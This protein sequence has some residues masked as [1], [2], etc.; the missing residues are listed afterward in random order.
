M[1]TT[2]SLD[3]MKVAAQPIEGLKVYTIKNTV[4]FGDLDDGVAIGDGDTV[5]L[6]KVPVNT[7]VLA[8]AVNV[9]TAGAAST[10]YTCTVGDGA[11]PDGFIKTVD[12]T[13]TGIT[14]TAA[15]AVETYGM[16]VGGGHVYSTADTIDAVVTITGG[17]SHP[18]VEVTAICVAL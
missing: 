16:A 9:T 1:A 15:D 13:A 14:K 3:S 7:I 17:T 11:N 12:L 4:D 8:V 5:E 18:V 2:H 10:A 6:L